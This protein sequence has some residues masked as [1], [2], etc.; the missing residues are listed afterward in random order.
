M[1]AKITFTLDRDLIDHLRVISAQTM[2]PQSRIVEL[3][4]KIRLDAMESK[5]G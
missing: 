3:A 4:I 2:I 5:K 1:K